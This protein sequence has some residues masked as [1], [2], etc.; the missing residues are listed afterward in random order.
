MFIV[1]VFIPGIRDMLLCCLFY[2][3]SA[4]D[5]SRDV[6]P[7]LVEGG[8]FFIFVC[9][10]P[11]CF[12]LIEFHYSFSFSYLVLTWYVYYYCIWLGFNTLVSCSFARFLLFSL[13]GLVTGCDSLL[14]SLFSSVLT[15]VYASS[16]PLLLL[17]EFHYTFFISY[18]ILL[19]WI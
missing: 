3:L 8:Y 4:R 11:F 10:S 14:G 1:I 18:K 6:T 15:F 13:K 5:Q 9:S 19:L 7:R 16:F 2:C 12:L 17:P